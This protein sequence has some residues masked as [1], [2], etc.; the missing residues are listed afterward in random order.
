MSEEKKQPPVAKYRKG[1]IC[2]SKWER[3][4]EDKIFYNF[5]LEMSYFDKESDSFKPATSMD[6]TQLLNLQACLQKAI[7]ES[8]KES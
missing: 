2:I 4:A 7:S 5:S 8:V 1:L 6:E 3:K